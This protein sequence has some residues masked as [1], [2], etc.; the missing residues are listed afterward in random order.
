MTDARKL[1]EHLIKATV[2]EN[3]DGEALTISYLAEGGEGETILMKREPIQWLAEYMGIVQ[4]RNVQ[5]QT[6]QEID[7]TGGDL[8][9]IWTEDLAGTS[10]A[11]DCDFTVWSMPDDTVGEDFV[12]FLSRN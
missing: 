7:E 5:W 2:T 4:T 3:G 11:D 6:S 8:V 1:A 10:L 12:N 9:R